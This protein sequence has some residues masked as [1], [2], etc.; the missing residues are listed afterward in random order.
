MQRINPRYLNLVVILLIMTGISFFFSS[1]QKIKVEKV[2][3][4]GLP[5]KFENWQGKDLFIEKEILDVLRTDSVLMRD[6]TNETGKKITLTIVY[7]QDNRVDFHLPEACSV[8]EG[9]DIYEKR[10]ETLLLGKEKEPQALNLLLVKSNRSSQ[11]IL[12]YFESGKFI[13]DNYFLS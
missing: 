4:S 9:S 10:K 6:Y 1:F 3:I 2:D 7:Y 11:I 13:T 12:Y 8:G 5:N